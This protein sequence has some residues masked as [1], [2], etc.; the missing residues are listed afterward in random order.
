MIEDIR[1]WP[2]PGAPKAHYLQVKREGEWHTLT[3][4]N[5]EYNNEYKRLNPVQVITRKKKSGVWEFV[6]AFIGCTLV[7]IYIGYMM[8]KH[9]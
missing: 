2:V 6:L 7:V 1:Y 5:D 8:L 9:W 3:K 4:D